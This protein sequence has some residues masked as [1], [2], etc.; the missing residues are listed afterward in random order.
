MPELSISARLQRLSTTTA[1]DVLSGLGLARVAMLGIGPIVP[2]AGTLAGPAR[3]LRFLPRR[4][5]VGKGR[6]AVNRQL[7]DVLE[8]GEVLVV[9]AHG[10]TNGAVLGDMLAARA[11]ARG[12]AGVVADGV[13]RDTTGLAEMG[14]PIF[15][16]G[17]FP[18]RSAPELLAWDADV[19]IQCGGVFVQ[20][21][22][23]ILGDADG[24]IV[25]PDALVAQ[26]LERGEAALASDEFSQ[27]LLAA[28]FMLD[29]AYPLPP[30]LKP[31]LARYWQDGTVPSI[32]EFRARTAG[33]T[34]R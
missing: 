29:E 13:V 27:R 8:S 10:C 6:G 32:A 31:D 9:D 33:D 25:I 1:S 18:A 2:A 34:A 5:D 28:G 22:D 7:I 24:V 23:W 20:P 17:V 15:A 11:R 3:T 21:G 16:R 30:A 4:E 12:C 14:T 19:A 26:V